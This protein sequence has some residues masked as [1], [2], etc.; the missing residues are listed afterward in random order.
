MIA[1]GKMIHDYYCVDCGRKHRGEEISFDLAEFLGLKNV[2]DSTGSVSKVTMISVEQ[3]KK[4]AE[5]S[6]IDASLLHGNPSKIHITLREFL[7]IMAEN[8]GGMELKNQMLE[9]TRSELEDAV[10]DVIDTGLVNEAVRVEMKERYVS[11]LSNK[12]IYTCTLPKEDNLGEKEEMNRENLDNYVAQFW[13]QPEFFEEGKSDQIYTVT[14]SDE[15]NPVNMKEM[16]APRKIRGY[17]PD[18]GK[19]V[20]ENTGKYPHILIGLLGIQSAGKTSLIVSMI[21]EMMSHYNRY[22][23][24]F[25][26]NILCDSRY[27]YMELNKKLFRNGWAVEKTA[28]ETNTA[29]FNASL[30]LTSEG[31]EK[32]AIYT[33]IDIAGEM[34]Y[35]KE[36]QTVRADALEMYPLINSCQCYLLCTSINQKNY[37]NAESQKKEIAS[38]EGNMSEE[39]INPQ[40][41]MIIVQEIYK[42]L[43]RSDN[44]LRPGKLLP[45]E[46]PPLCVVATKA[47]KGSFNMIDIDEDILDKSIFE[48][49]SQTRKN[50]LDDLEISSELFHKSRLEE[51]SDI[52]AQLSNEDIQEAI[53]RCCEVIRDMKQTTYVSMMSC[54]ALGRGAAKYEGDTNAISYYKNEEG[55]KVLFSPVYLEDLWKWILQVT[56]L[57]EVE[58]TGYTFSAIP[59]YNESYILNNEVEEDYKYR[60]KFHISESE[61]RINAVRHLFL[62]PSAFDCEI[63]DAWNEEVTFFE[64]LRHITPERR[65]D[66]L[67]RN[68]DI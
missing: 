60:K 38:E 13:V 20:L 61:S 29:T 63:E 66:A 17:C 64:R 21:E 50:P 45:L 39:K 56:G 55:R 67:V 58:G 52:Y 42:K 9:Y 24:K 33:F 3:L 65:V 54:S 27:P 2:L 36:T 44:I 62:N 47:D 41:A 30:L 34:C 6:G 48:Q 31:A 16:V 28:A 59:S 18:C 14:Y 10:E 12:F 57:I 43:R 37:G 25:P 46:I 49:M 35:D 26:N 7:M 53:D 32:K 40:A 68:H 22:K 4:F 11:A 51:M 8:V 5:R 15:A 23:V 19:P 1:G